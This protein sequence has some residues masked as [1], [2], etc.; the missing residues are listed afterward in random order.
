MRRRSPDLEWLPAVPF[1][2][3]LTLEAKI[4]PIWTCFV[5]L[6]HRGS[7]CRWTYLAR[8]Y[9][10]Y[11][12]LDLFGAVRARLDLWQ[13]VGRTVRRWRPPMHAGGRESCSFLPGEKWA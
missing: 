10:D 4:L 9:L 11:L 5:D 6:E 13:R 1:S 7:D 8:K 2:R 12:A 3:V